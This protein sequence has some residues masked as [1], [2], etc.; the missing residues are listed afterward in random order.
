MG[1][2]RYACEVCC[3][4]FV[5]LGDWY[6]VSTSWGQNRI[7]PE[8]SIE[9]LERSD[10]IWVVSHSGP[11]PRG[12]PDSDDLVSAASKLS[13]ASSENN[14]DS[15][16]HAMQC[17][18]VY[19]SCTLLHATI[20]IRQAVSKSG[21]ANLPSEPSLPCA[22]FQGLRPGD[23]TADTTEATSLLCTR[24]Q[25]TYGTRNDAKNSD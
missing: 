24:M 19:R 12:R 13:A 21:S 7:S 6:T 15:D 9:V 20:T 17:M 22:K 1:G 16:S 3:G 10:G 4:R 11:T 18:S 25:T 2:I 8:A 5:E 23:F 14:R